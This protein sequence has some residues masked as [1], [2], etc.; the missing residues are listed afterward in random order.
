MSKYVPKVGDTGIFYPGLSQADRYS[1]GPA[2]GPGAQPQS[3]KITK[4]WSDT[5]VNLECQTA[6]PTSVF[7]FDEHAEAGVQRPAG[8]YFVPDAKPVSADA[9]AVPGVSGSV[10]AAVDPIE[11]AIQAKGL[12][13][14]RITPE[15]IK[16]AIV[17]EHYFSADQG[18]F[19]AAMDIDGTAERRQL[20]HLS[21]LTFCVL[22]LRNGF[23]VTGESAC[24]SPE[25]FNAEIG[26]KLAREAAINKLYPLL[27]YELK[28]KLANEANRVERIARICNDANA[29]YCAATGDFSYGTWDN[30]PEG[31]KESVRFGVRQHL[32]NP[33]LT[34]ESSHEAWM[35]FKAADGYTYG[36]VRDEATKQHPCMVPYSELP[37]AQKAKDHIFRAAV[38]AANRSL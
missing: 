14:P 28:T 8:Y 30:A 22:V 7:V 23:T 15:D 24:A 37:M 5:C 32:A 27:G 13:A 6:M 17:S 11:A 34:P 2:N 25:N 9:P 10:S 36:P 3:A 4:V 12:T 26:R 18:V 31:I 29:A 1:R 19:G 38:H 33:D 35:K 16:A 20:P 21:L